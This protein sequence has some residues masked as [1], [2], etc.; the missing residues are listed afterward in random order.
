MTVPAGSARSH[1][2]VV[3]DRQLLAELMRI[4]GETDPEVV[5]R[6]ALRGLWRF[7]NAQRSVARSRAELRP[8]SLLRPSPAVSHVRRL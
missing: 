8:R 3:V 4:S 1:E 7:H 6:R 2:T 5:L